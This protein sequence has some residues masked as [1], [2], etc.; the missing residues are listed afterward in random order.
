MRTA[1]LYR[2]RKREMSEGPNDRLSKLLQIQERAR[3]LDRYWD[4]LEVEGVFDFKGKDAGETEA[5]KFQNWIDQ[6]T[7]T[8]SHTNELIRII[9]E[10]EKTGDCPTDLL[11]WVKDAEAMK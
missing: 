4:S 10:Y 5:E 8:M 7:L 11:D 6:T 3:D 9:R 1:V 2:A